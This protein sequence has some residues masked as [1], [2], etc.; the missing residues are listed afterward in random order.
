MK[1]KHINSDKA[2]W[3]ETDLT[4]LISEVS[5]GTDKQSKL[6]LPNVNRNRRLGLSQSR[7]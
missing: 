6:V 1:R 7:H 3:K 2:Q 4:T 5:V